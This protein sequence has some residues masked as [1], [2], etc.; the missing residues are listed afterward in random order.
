MFLDP[1]YIILVSGERV[2]D[3]RNPTTNQPTIPRFR[4]AVTGTRMCICSD[5]AQF[6]D[7]ARLIY[8]VFGFPALDVSIAI[9]EREKETGTLIVNWQLAS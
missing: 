6:D 8:P 4:A 5:A 9:R 3:A 7:T 2:G 1:A